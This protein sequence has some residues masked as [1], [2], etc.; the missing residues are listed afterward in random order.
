MS[1]DPAYYV[2]AKLVFFF[3]LPPPGP[4]AQSI[5]TRSKKQ[6]IISSALVNRKITH[7]RTHPRFTN[8]FTVWK[9][10]LSGHPRNYTFTQFHGRHTQTFKIKVVRG[11]FL[12]PEIALPPPGRLATSCTL[13]APTAATPNRRPLL[14]YNSCLLPSPSSRFNAVGV[15]TVAQTDH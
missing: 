10:P 6:L 7:I 14:R 9:T 1:R 8:I 4:L 3:A 12:P 13:R 5:F 15:L 11:C 2:S